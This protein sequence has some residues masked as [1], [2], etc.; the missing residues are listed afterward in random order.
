MAMAKAA[1]LALVAAL[2]VQ[3]AA[4]A[5]DHPVNGDGAWDTSGTD[6]NTWATKQ[7]FVQGDTVSF[8]YSTSH[9]VTEVT[10]AGYKACSGSSAVKSYTGGKTAVKLATPGKHYFICSIPGHCAAGMKLEVTVAAAGV[11]A[12][13]PTKSKS[14]PSHKKSA[15]PA[16]APAAQAP[17]AATEV[18]TPAPAPKASGAAAA[19]VGVKA[20][21]GLAAGVALVLAIMS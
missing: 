1:I 9:D 5:T 13:A 8:T 15:A 20:V 14:K 4:A 6:Y 18:S 2:A 16:P 17:D 3:L 19:A 10:E 12:P 11:S 21:V 7:K